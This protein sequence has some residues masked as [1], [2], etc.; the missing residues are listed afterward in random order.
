MRT[1]HHL[2]TTLLAAA[3]LLAAGCGGE[4]SE[5]EATSDTD[6]TAADDVA[7]TDE[8]AGEEHDADDATQDQAAD[9]EEPEEPQESDEPEDDGLLD[10]LSFEPQPLF[11]EYRFSHDQPDFPEGMS[12]AQ[13]GD[14]FA[15]F[16][17]VQGMEMASFVDGDELVASCFD[18]GS[19]WMCLEQDLGEQAPDTAFDVELFEGPAVDEVELSDHLVDAYPDEIGD[20]DAICGRS[21]EVAPG[22]GEIC[23][24]T[25]TGMLLRAETIVD[26]DDELLF[27]AVEVREA[28][29]VDFTPPAEPESFGG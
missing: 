12:V 5:P 21:S 7:E 26:A 6:E 9:T 17:A 29:D 1:H 4:V 10:G 23:F 20:R 11:I 14:R 15:T 27:E 18:D 3:A 28:T 2:T 22:E 19:G 8:T 24:D 25:V 16:V 13:D